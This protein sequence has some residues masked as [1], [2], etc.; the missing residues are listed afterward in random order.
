MPSFKDMLKQDLDTF[1]NPDE[2]GDLALYSGTGLTIQILD[3]IAII[4]ETESAVNIIEVRKSD[5]PD[6]QEDDTFTID[7]IVFRN[8]GED[9]TSSSELM[10]KIQIERI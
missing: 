4:G 10:M 6:L 2:F 7:N 3:S 1:L 8:L 5:V 9:Y